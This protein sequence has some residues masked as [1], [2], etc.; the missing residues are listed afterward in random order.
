MIHKDNT[1]DM[2]QMPSCDHLRF[3]RKHSPKRAIQAPSAIKERE[4]AGTGGIVSSADQSVLLAW[5]WIRSC[6]VVMSVSKDCN[7]WE[8][9]V[10][11]T[12][13]AAVRG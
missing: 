1:V 3:S 6:I 13:I 12:R 2:K 8:N 11:R 10:R 7:R 9:E 5:K 4:R